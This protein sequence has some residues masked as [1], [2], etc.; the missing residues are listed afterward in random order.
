MDSK[1]S[2]LSTSPG[3]SK[4]VKSK[5]KPVRTIDKKAQSLG[6]ME[7]KIS[8][9]KEKTFYFRL[10]LCALGREFSFTQFPRAKDSNWTSK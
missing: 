8:P 10:P 6:R 3:K 7:L 1:G 2:Y 5:G 4:E 9:L